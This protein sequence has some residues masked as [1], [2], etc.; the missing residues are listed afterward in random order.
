MPIPRKEATE[1]LKKSKLRYGGFLV[2]PSVDSD[3]E[4]IDIFS[5]ELP[6]YRKTEFD[7]A[8]RIGRKYNLKLIFEDFS[9]GEGLDKG[10]RPDYE[11][12]FVLT[13][14]SIDE[15]KEASKKISE[16]IIELKRELR[17]N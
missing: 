14:T 15:L 2:N 5:E 13:C 7:V 8:E 6:I 16:S 10:M 11:P 9:P 17:K 3:Y 4:R 1:F 12:V